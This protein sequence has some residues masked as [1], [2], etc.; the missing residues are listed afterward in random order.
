MAY[1]YTTQVYRIKR[2]HNIRDFVYKVELEGDISLTDLALLLNSLTDEAFFWVEGNEYLHATSEVDWV[3][4]LP[5]ELKGSVKKAE[6]IREGYLEESKLP[7]YTAFALFA[8][9]FNKVLSPNFKANPLFRKLRRRTKEGWNLSLWFKFLHETGLNYKFEEDGIEYQVWRWFAVKPERFEYI[10]LA[11]KGGVAINR[12]FGEFVKDFDPETLKK[13]FAFRVKGSYR[14]GRLKELKGETALLQFDGG[15]VSEVPTDRLVPIY[16][17]LGRGWKDKDRSGL[18]KHLRL[19]PKVICKYVELFGEAM[20][21]LL[22]PFMVKLEKSEPSWEKVEVSPYVVVD[23]PVEEERVLEYIFEERKVYST[24]EGELKIN[25]IDLVLKGEKNKKLLRDAK[26]DFV[27]NL[28]LF[29]ND[30]G[31]SVEVRE[32]VYDKK[33]K[34]LTREAAK[35]VEEFLKE[36]GGELS[37]ASL[38]IVLIPEAESLT[39]NILSLAGVEHLKRSLKG[40]K[41][42]L[43]TDRVVKVFFKSQKKETKREILFEVLKTLF[44]LNGASLYILDEPLPIGSTALKTERG[45]EIYNLFGELLEIREEPPSVEDGVVIAS[46]RFEREKGA[47]AVDKWTTP[48]A[49]KREIESGRCLSAER[50]IAFDLLKSKALTVLDKGIPFDYK[51]AYGVE[52]T[53]DLDLNE[54]KKALVQLSKVFDYSELQ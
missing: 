33:V 18:L 53:E 39:E 34:L 10:T 7:L 22:E 21:Q 5:E 12:P 52:I 43:L 27:E 48:Y 11:F 17:P 28:K 19:T 6:R 49:I 32:L 44:K 25:L 23:R 1:E 35:E 51:T 36:H 14:V 20:N 40:T 3:G 24:P 45:Y 37:E 38:N 15:F 8:A 9:D 29:L 54:V 50:G 41:Y 42:H 47:I 13:Y 31:V 46:E 16:I 4:L 26:A 2:I 30:I